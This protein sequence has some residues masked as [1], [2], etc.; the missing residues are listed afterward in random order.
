LK[1]T[2]IGVPQNEIEGVMGK[3]GSVL[4][5]S[6]LIFHK[7]YYQYWQ[8]KRLRTK[9]RTLYPESKG[10]PKPT[11]RKSFLLF[12]NYQTYEYRH[13]VPSLLS[14]MVTLSSFNLQ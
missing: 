5:N 12:T 7:K 4:I 2:G 14:S 10:L 8:T 9:R 1:F 3:V 13:F 11:P 6:T